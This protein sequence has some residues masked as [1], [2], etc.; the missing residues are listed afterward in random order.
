M[1]TLHKKDIIPYEKND[2]TWVSVTI[3]MDPNLLMY[4]RSVYTIFDL[5]SDLGGLNGILMTI[6]GLICATWNYNAFD[7]RMVKRLFKIRKPES[8]I[9]PG[10]VYF[11]KSDFI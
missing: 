11:K 6:F 5:L 9:E 3:E 7:N 2:S 1:F 4:E 10:A 8:E